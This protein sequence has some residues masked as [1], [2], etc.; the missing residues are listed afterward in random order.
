MSQI[1]NNYDRKNYFLLFL[2]SA[3]DNR[4]D[5]TVLFSER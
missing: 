2:H 4:L 5:I 1:Y 3:F